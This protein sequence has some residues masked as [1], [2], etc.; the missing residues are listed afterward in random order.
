MP[1]GPDRNGTF[2][3][4]LS[5][6][7]VRRGRL[8]LFVLGAAIAGSQAGHLLVFQ[9][10]FGA[11]ALPLQAAG[12]HAYFPGVAKTVIGAFALASLAALAVVAAARLAAGRRIEKASAP[13]PVRL[14]AVLFTA[15]LALF[16]VQ[17]AVEAV[18][19]GEH[20]ATPGEVLLWGTAGQLPV[21]LVAAYALRWLAARLEPSL[22]AIASLHHAA[23]PFVAAVAASPRPAPARVRVDGAGGVEAFHR[24]GPPSF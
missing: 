18:L 4:D 17:E 16:A 12:P 6:K 1:A 8:R 13:S 11:A 20:L 2:G 15:Q 19:G 9:L 10:R 14:L 3:L 24:R 23:Q 21:A 22:R 5:S 7:A